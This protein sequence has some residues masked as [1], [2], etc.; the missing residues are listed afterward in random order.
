MLEARR[1]AVKLESMGDWVRIFAGKS[2][3]GG[4]GSEKEEEKLVG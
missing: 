4:I 1:R 2:C 3:H